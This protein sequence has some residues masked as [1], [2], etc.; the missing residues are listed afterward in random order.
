MTDNLMFIAIILFAL[1]ATIY[2]LFKKDY[3]LDEEEEDI[4]SIDYLCRAVKERINELTDTSIIDHNLSKEAAKKEEA[5]KLELI[6]ATRTCG[7][8]DIN[9]KN[10]VKDNIKRIIQR[11]L[12]VNEETIDSIISFEDESKLSKED[13]FDIVLYLYKKK[14]GLDGFYYMMKEN[15]FDQLKGTGTRDDEYHYEVS[16]DDILALYNKMDT[17]LDYL[18]KI[19]IVAQRIYSI[20]LGN[21]PIDE[22][23]DMAKL[24][25]VSAGLSGRMKDHYDYLEE[26]MIE[27]REEIE[28]YFNSIWFMFQGKTIHLTAIGFGK[29]S[30]M[31]RVCKNIYRYDEPGYLSEDEGFIISSMKDGSRIVV[32]RPKNAE[33]WAFFIR[34]LNSVE[35]ISIERLITDPGADK[36]IKIMEWLTRGC[37]NIAVTGKQFSGKT[38]LLKS[39]AEFICPTFNIGV[40]EMIFELHYKQIRRYKHRNINTLRD[41][42]SRSP[43]EILDAFKKMDR[44]VFIFGEV[45]NPLAF[46]LVMQASMSGARQLLLSQH[47]KTTDY[48]MDSFKV[49]LQ[50]SGLFPSEIKVAEEQVAKCINFDFHM[51]TTMDGHIYLERITEIIP[52]IENKFS[53]D[54]NMKENL[55]IF[56]DKL[57]NN[58]KYKTVNILEFKDGRYQV[59]AAPSEETRSRLAEYLSPEVMEEYDKF[60]RTNLEGVA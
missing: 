26:Y 2:F 3:N 33:N 54:K 44:D 10:Y 47:A 38:T 34:K 40:Q 23:R 12:G 48:F 46:S 27:K 11:D 15:N 52:D 7:Y 18:D 55:V 29:E 39:L 31:I 17:R 56:F 43:Q 25:G 20:N 13:R 16:A 45:H 28:Y 30:E 24:D 49:G 60:F 51:N 58:K 4:F 35:D 9:A 21:G 22:L 36:A 59:V 5:R 8:G 14:Y 57:V 41:T 42:K 6:K 32:V 53:V 19:E 1:L 50:I 37:S